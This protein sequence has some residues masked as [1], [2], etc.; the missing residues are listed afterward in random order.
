[1]WKLV[2]KLKTKN[3]SYY[4]KQLDKIFSK[5]IRLRDWNQCITCGGP[6]N[7]AGHFMSRRFN[8]TRFNEQNVNCQCYRCNV[9]FYGEQYKYAQELDLK[10]GEGTAKKLAD[11]AKIEKRFTLQEVLDLITYYTDQVDFYHSELH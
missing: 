3:V 7:Q 4:K 5:Y 2:K 11:L 8:N 9:I 1:M 10:Y 6:G